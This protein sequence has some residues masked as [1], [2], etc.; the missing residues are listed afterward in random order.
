MKE[1]KMYTGCDKAQAG[2]LEVDEIMLEWQG[3]D[4]KGTVIYAALRSFNLSRR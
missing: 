3:I 1:K 2:R 4:C